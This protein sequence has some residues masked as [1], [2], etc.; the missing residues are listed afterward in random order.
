MLGF[1]CQMNPTVSIRHGGPWCAAGITGAAAVP[2]LH[3]PSQADSPFDSQR[4]AL[5]SSRQSSSAYALASSA[6]AAA[7][8]ATGPSASAPRASRG[9]V[10]M[11]QLS[12]SV[13]SELASQQ[14]EL[15]AAAWRHASLSSTACAQGLEQQK[16]LVEGDKQTDRAQASAECRFGGKRRKKNSRHAVDPAMEHVQ[17]HLQILKHVHIKHASPR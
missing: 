8:Q 12:E 11:H 15:Q 5:S 7:N 3:F 14:P 16:E 17:D 10:V 6:A 1:N 13:L 2:L 9:S 4:S